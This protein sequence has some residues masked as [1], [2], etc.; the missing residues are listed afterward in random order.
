MCFLCVMRFL[1]SQDGIPLASLHLHPSPPPPRSG[2][3][4]PDIWLHGPQ[5]LAP[6]RQVYHGEYTITHTT[7]RWS[8]GPVLF[9]GG[10]FSNIVFPVL[11]SAAKC[12]QLLNG[13]MNKNSVFL[14]ET[15]KHTTHMNTR[16]YY[17]IVVR[18]YTWTPKCLC[19]RRTVFVPDWNLILGL[20]S[21]TGP[22][23]HGIVVENNVVETEEI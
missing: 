11:Q 18:L 14:M 19:C 15:H 3:S 13:G 7:C 22:A 5:V 6:H 9:G 17:V 20:S 2:T 8:S 21:I 4:Q 12:F 10:T 1:S 23:K 16:T